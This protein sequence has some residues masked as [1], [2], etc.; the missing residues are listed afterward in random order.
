MS[1]QFL[2]PSINPVGE[3]VSVFVNDCVSSNAAK[4][5]L[6]IVTKGVIRR[7]SG[8]TSIIPVGGSL[9]YTVTL[10]HNGVSSPIAGAVVTIP[11][12]GVILGQSV[13]VIISQAVVPGDSLVVTVGGS[14]TA[15]STGGVSFSL[16]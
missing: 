1:N 15:A 14:Q 8:A 13:S 2:P 16:S 6:P 11:T 10:I 12:V 5:V 3:Q 7:I 4:V 9:S